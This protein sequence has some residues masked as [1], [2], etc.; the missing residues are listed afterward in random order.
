[1]TVKKGSPSYELPD[2]LRAQ[3]SEKLQKKMI[4]GALSFRV[5]SKKTL[6][7]ILPLIDSFY[8]DRGFEI[9]TDARNPSDYHLKVYQHKSRS[10]VTL[11]AIQG[12]RDI[13]FFVEDSE[14]SEQKELRYLITN[15]Y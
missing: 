12:K 2:F 6:D 7:S 13:A 5:L 8:K 9:E 1:M 4:K 11:Q 15:H 14:T 3:S 10:S